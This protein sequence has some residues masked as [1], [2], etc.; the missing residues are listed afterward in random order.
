MKRSLLAASLLLAFS[1]AYADPQTTAFTYQ[2]NLTA[3]G[4]PANGN[5]NLTFK[6]FD[7]A[8][9][10]NQIGSSIVMSAFPVVNGRFITDLNFPGVF[11]AQQRW[12]EVTVGTQTL[13]PRQPVGAAPVAQFALSGGTNFSFSATLPA[14]TPLQLFQNEYVTSQGTVT[15]TE[16]NGINIAPVSCSSMTLRAVAQQPLP[17]NASFQF[18]V[19]HYPGSSHDA[20]GTA[21]GVVGSCLISTDS[22]S[23]VQSCTSTQSVTFQAGDGYS[24]Y[25][26]AVTS[27]IPQPVLVNVYC[28]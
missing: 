3:N 17:N 19:L 8:T 9:S 11:G 23:A 14:G 20:A 1:A 18:V 25:F 27:T 13:V 28:Q 7:A 5:F 24:I 15:S 2:G 6:L 21:D 4:Q 16:A 22:F 26:F 10:G 12:V